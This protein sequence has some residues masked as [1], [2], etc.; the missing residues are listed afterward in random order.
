MDLEDTDDGDCE[1]ELSQDKWCLFCMCY[2]INSSKVWNFWSLTFRAITVSLAV[3]LVHLESLFISISNSNRLS[4][5][6]HVWEVVRARNRCNASPSFWTC[7]PGWCCCLVQLLATQGL[8]WDETLA[9]RGCRCEDERE[10]VNDRCLCTFFILC[11]L[12]GGLGGTSPR[13]RTF[14]SYYLSFANFV[15]LRLQF[16]YFS[17]SFFF[18]LPPW[19]P[20]V[21]RSRTCSPHNLWLP[22]VLMTDY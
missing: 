21:V 15:K 6:R 5:S 20:L 10:G 16:F 4:D 9:A 3:T 2:L 12:K 13:H 17:F 14:A 18:F 19:D 1:R 8:R 22:L 11:R 7:A